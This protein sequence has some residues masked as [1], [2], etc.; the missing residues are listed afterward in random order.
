MVS[1]SPSKFEMEKVAV[2]RLMRR[3]GQAVDGYEDPNRSRGAAGESGADVVVVSNA[4]R[5]GVQVTDLDTGSTPGQ[6]RAAESKLAREAESRGST[7][8]TSGQNDPQKDAR[9]RRF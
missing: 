5:I 9:C 8:S 2:V 6:A 1:G 7:Y 3:L 4:R